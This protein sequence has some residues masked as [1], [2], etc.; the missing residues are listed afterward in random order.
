[1]RL[2]AAALLVAGGL[3]APATSSVAKNAGTR[4][5]EFLAIDAG[6]RHVA[7][8]GTY[9]A[10]GHDVFSAHGQPAA[11]ADATP[12]RAGY[13]EEVGFQ[14]N[15]WVQDIS[16]Q[17]LGFSGSLGP[18]RWALTV[19]VLG[20]SDIVR[21]TDDAFGRFGA[22][23]GTFGVQDYAVTGYFARRMGSR[24]SVGA[25]AKFLRSEIDDVSASGFA[26][27]L[28]ARYRA[29]EQWT[30]GA[31]VVNVGQGLK[32]LRDRSDLPLTGRVGAAWH[33][34]SWLATADVLFADRESV[35]G[36]AGLEWRPVD[37]IS[38][39]AGYKTQLNS[40]LGEGLTAGVGF[41]VSNFTLD[42]GYVPFGPLGDAHRVSAGIRF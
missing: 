6:G 39:R 13:F 7:L 41:H 14:Y 38:L 10:Y 37:L 16:Q 33:R 19:N 5:S 20:A 26:F 1:M 2:L 29:S 27:D 30:L 31:S 40:D 34:G 4:G 28:G 21:T 24:W 32:F 18:G 3:A 15:E 25:A 23:N 17:Y 22:T 42:Y 9:A 12:E 11:I 8:G 35:E 36:A